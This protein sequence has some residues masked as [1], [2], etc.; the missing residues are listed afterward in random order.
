[1]NGQ[2]AKHLFTRADYQR[3]GES[4]I[5]SADPRVELLDGE[6]LQMSPIGSRHAGCVGALNRLLS[7]LGSAAL[8]WPQNPIILND[9]SEPQPDL[10]LLRPRPDGYRSR[11][12]Q[13]PDILL[14]IDVMDSSTSYD[15]SLK[16]PAYA[17]ARIPEVWLVD[18]ETNVVESYRKPHGG[19]YH[20]TTIYH[21][22]QRLRIA[23]LP[24]K[25]FRVTEILG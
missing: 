24:A 25:T 15:R 10:A 4:G 17:N 8:I 12:P 6:V 3:M 21:R 18:L 19:S 9:Y 11:H 22:G 23:A 20:E 7:R 5:F 1:M 2:A 16:L 13:P 14:I